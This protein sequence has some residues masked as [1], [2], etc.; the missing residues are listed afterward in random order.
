[1]DDSA[2]PKKNQLLKAESVS[3]SPNTLSELATAGHKDNQESAA[4]AKKNDDELLR[5]WSNNSSETYTQKSSFN[6]DNGN[7]VNAELPKNNGLLRD[8]DWSNNLSETHTQKSSSND[9]DA[10]SAMFAAIKSQEPVGVMNKVRTID[11]NIQ[12]QPQISAVRKMLAPA[13]A[14]V[15]R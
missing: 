8:W 2:L 1:M 10:R 12:Q 5:A 14:N 3:S 7:Q 4:L 6:L 11:T 15:R 13:T 9:G